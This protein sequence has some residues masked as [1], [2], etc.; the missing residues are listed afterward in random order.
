M[1]KRSMVWLTGIVL[2]CTICGVGAQ[3]RINE[4]CAVASDR[5]IRWDENGFAHVGTGGN[6]YDKD[7]DASGWGSNT[8]PIGM[9]T[10]VAT[11]LAPWMELAAPSLYLRRPFS[12]SAAQAADSGALSLEVV[13]T[14]GFV[15]YLNGTEI[16]RKNAA[17][18][19]APLM[20]DQAAY[21]GAVR[22]ITGFQNTVWTNTFTLDAASA[23]LVEG[24]NV[25]AIQ[26]QS[27]D[28]TF[29]DTSLFCK[30]VLNTPPAVV[31]ANSGGTW[32]WF[33]GTDEPSGGVVDPT[34]ARTSVLPWAWAETKFN[35]AAWA[36]G[37]GGIG[38]GDGDDATDVEILMKGKATTLYMRRAFAVADTG[39]TLEFMVDYDDGFV[40][41]LNGNEIARRNAGT[42]GSVVPYDALALGIHESGT[43]ITIALGSAL[44]FLHAGTNVLAIQ[45]LNRT[46]NSSDLTMKA[47]LYTQE[48][49]SFVEFGDEWRYFVGTEEPIPPSDEDPVDDPDSGFLDWI[50]LKNEGTQPVS[51]VGWRLTDDAGWLDKWV[52][53]DVTLP[54]GGQLVVACSEVDIRDTT[55]H[56]LHTG[57]NLSRNGEYLGLY[58]AS[59]TMVSE[60]A[61][62]YPEQH[63]LFTYGWDETTGSYR[64]F[65]LPTPGEDNAGDT[66]AVLP[67]PPEIEMDSGFYD[68]SIEVAI[69]TSLAGASVYTTTNGSAPTAAI[70]TLYDGPLTISANTALRA[71]T[72]SADGVAS[73]PATR[74]YLMNAPEALKSLPALCMV[75]DEEQTFFH[76]HGI[77]AIVGGVYTNTDKNRWMPVTPDDYHSPVMHGRPYER[78]VC[79]DVVKAGTNIWTQLDCGVRIVASSFSRSKLKFLPA[80]MEGTWYGDTTKNKAQFNLFVRGIYGDDEFENRLIPESPLEALPQ[81]RVR[82][83]KNDWK[84]PF[85]RDE[86]MRR[87]YSDMGH[88]CSVGSLVG[89]WVNGTYRCFYNPCERYG[90]PF[91]QARFNS[92]LEWDALSHD[93]TYVSRYNANEGDDVAWLAMYDFIAANDMS[94]YSNYVAVSQMVDVEN[95]TDYLLVNIYGG[96]KDWGNNNWHASRERSI[97]GR[98]RYHVWDAESALLTLD[99]NQFTNRL[100]QANPMGK[101]YRALA[102]SPDYAV[103]MQDRIAEHFFNG[104]ALEDAAILAK[105]NG[106]A[107][108]LDP[109]MQYVHGI[110]VNRTKIINWINGR[111]A[112]VLQQ[113]RDAGFWHDLSRPIISPDGEGFRGQIEVS[114]ANTNGGGVVYYTLDGS[115]PRAPGGAAQGVA[116]AAPM[117]LTHS[118]QLKARVFVNGIWGPLAEAIFPREDPEVLLTEVHYHPV[119][120][121]GG[122]PYDSDD[123]E[124]V[125][126]YNSGT[127]TLNLD[128]YSLDG[129]IEFDFDADTMLGPDEYLV[130]AHDLAA[131]TSR[132]D[133]NGMHLV[134]EYSGK[135]SDGGENIRLEFFGEKLFDIT[136]NDGRGW[137]KAADGAG[138]SLVP[139]SDSI[140]DQGFDILD[141]PFNWRAST[142]IHGSPGMA[143]PESPPAIVINEI[144]AHTDTGNPEPFDSNDQ[145][146]LFNPTDAAAVLDGYW[147]LSDDLSD[148]MQWNIPSGTII[149]AGGWVLFDENDF[150]PGRTTGFGLD[151]AGEQVVLSHHPGAG[152][153]RVVD[154]VVFEGQ[155]RGSSWGRYPDGDEFFQTLEPTPNAANEL[156][157]PGIRIQELMYNPR[158]LDG[159]NAD[160]VLEYIMLTNCSSQAIALDGLPDTTN[161]WRMNGGVDYSF[162]P[163]TSMAAGECLWLVPFDPVAQPEQKALFCAVYGLDA[164]SVRLLGR[165]AGD[166][167]NSGERITLECPQASDDPLDPD[168]ISWIV[169]DEVTWLDEAPWPSG[170][171]GAGIPLVRC[172][173]AGNNPLSWMLPDDFDADQLPDEWELS[174]RGSLLDLGNG[175][176]DGD[177]QD[178]WAEFIAGTIPTD[179]DSLLEFSNCQMDPNC[180]MMDWNSV[181]GRVYSVSWSSNLCVQFLPIAE[182]LAYPR[183]SYTDE[184]YRAENAAFYR[185][186]VWTNSVPVE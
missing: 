135:L 150:H 70:G 14:D 138:P 103:F 167:S 128:E 46:L 116:Y 76:P 174:C 120:P 72:V 104:G 114:I 4:I 151:K 164:G 51:L 71:A 97:N 79:V 105:C 139:A 59:G 91:Y 178:D 123:F 62:T 141:H 130:V 117:E 132:Y 57:F 147:Y 134:G 11:D 109:M 27:N 143:D 19:G 67:Q 140:C 98:F 42:A 17:V 125:E 47:D 21:N 107:D 58:N 24:V 185:I 142:Y 163:G 149:P 166:L 186:G 88:V 5:L 15:A 7:F 179:A 13:Y 102:A 82:S 93:A 12:A 127:N 43:S 154:C 52:F 106:L 176:F 1:A 49:T 32:N 94:V 171:D 9:G 33:I 184:V 169:V 53:P 99:Y 168:D 113:L 177:G 29:S 180:F 28:E 131:F 39:G 8:G 74:N 34:Y 153:D 100:A 18:A 38:Y 56:M 23:L 110:V 78:R 136:Y 90:E 54:A 36:V 165:Y 81:V 64:Y 121:S 101:L 3:V 6:W 111:R 148:T 10:N 20:H 75:G 96:T 158:P 152:M 48:G 118:C 22:F 2:L 86:I 80:D 41:Y 115:D 45:V 25:L 68:G 69:T 65:H 84:N 83:G 162:A 16:A 40:A 155:A 124:F 44:D 60:I 182:D 30:A 31:L 159:Y 173:C 50:E 161:T 108:E 126:L 26:S 61:P 35:D 172:S 55:A 77:T 92:S 133:T 119:V 89:L 183:G 85:I 146:E 175:D 145:I 160:E 112:I 95:F 122:S 66:F 170:A 63:P 181:S 156:P 129:G 157:A 144:V 73:D 87:L 137:P 37:P